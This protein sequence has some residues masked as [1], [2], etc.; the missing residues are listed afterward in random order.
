[1][2]DAC[3]CTSDVSVKPLCKVVHASAEA[4]QVEGERGAAG[5]KRDR[6]RKKKAKLHQ[7]RLRMRPRLIDM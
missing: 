1:M 6:G 7:K 5:S 3:F 4:F 2:P